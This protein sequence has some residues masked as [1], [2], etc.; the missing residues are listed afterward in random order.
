MVI[1]I[2]FTWRLAINKLILNRMSRREKCDEEA[3]SRVEVGSFNWL[4]HRENPACGVSDFGQAPAPAPY[5]CFFCLS[6][7]PGYKLIPTMDCPDD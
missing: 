3:Q 4:F 1:G 5:L 7:P 6:I 2:C